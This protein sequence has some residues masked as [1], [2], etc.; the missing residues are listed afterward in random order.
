[1][2]NVIFKKYE[3]PIQDYGKML[4]QIMSQW[5]WDSEN[6]M[7][8][9]AFSYYRALKNDIFPN[10]KEDIDIEEIL[11]NE[12]SL[13]NINLSNLIITCIKNFPLQ[14]RTHKIEWWD[15]NTCLGCESEYTDI[16][17]DERLPYFYILHTELFQSYKLL[18]KV[19]GRLLNF[20]FH[21]LCPSDD[22]SI[23]NGRH[24]NGDLANYDFCATHIDWSNEN[25]EGT[26]KVVTNDNKE[27]FQN[28]ILPT[29]TNVSYFYIPCPNNIDFQFSYNIMN[30]IQSNY[31]GNL[32]LSTSNSNDSQNG[33]DQIFD[34]L[35]F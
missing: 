29:S 10:R 32:Q 33:I 34:N 30:L 13:N 35:P 25:I 12:L 17:E 22:N 24:M 21:D 8:E 5:A 16:Y 31:F 26:A 2:K 18:H 23:I 27:I 7:Y 28:L 15:G 6:L 20:T 1:M 3:K 11:T 14:F 4:D 19:S 9:D